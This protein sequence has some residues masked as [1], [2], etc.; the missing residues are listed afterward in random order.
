[1]VLNTLYTLYWLK[2]VSLVLRN[3]PSAEINHECTAKSG[4]AALFGF[5]AV[6]H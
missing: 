4:K 5:L 1:M 2:F 3:L 6:A